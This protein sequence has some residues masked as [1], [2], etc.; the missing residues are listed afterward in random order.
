MSGSMNRVTLIGNLGADPEGH[1]TRD[2][3]RIV[4]FSI[5]TTETWKDRNGERQERTEWHRIVAYNGI[6]EIAERFLRKGSRVYVEGQLPTR[7]WTDAE[8]TERLLNCRK[9][10]RASASE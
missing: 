9:C 10:C 2:G 1:N 6:G 3:R 7:K 4:R 5:A 8:G